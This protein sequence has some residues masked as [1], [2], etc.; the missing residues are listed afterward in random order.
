MLVDDSNVQSVISYDDTMLT[1]TSERETISQKNQVP[2][3]PF[4]GV[5]SSLPIVFRLSKSYSRFS[6]QFS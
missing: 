4:Q 5:R 3:C 1:M 6:M 2:L